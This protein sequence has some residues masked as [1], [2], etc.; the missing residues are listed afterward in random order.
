MLRLKSSIVFFI[1]LLSLPFNAALAKTETVKLNAFLQKNTKTIYYVLTLI[2]HH[3]M[4]DEN[5]YVILEADNNGYVQCI[6]HD[7]DQQIYCEASSG[8]YQGKYAPHLTSTQLRA[9][10]KQGFDMDA[11]HSNYRID[12]ITVRNSGTLWYVAGMMLE[13]LYRGY[14]VH[15]DFK[16]DAPFL[17]EARLARKR[18]HH[19]KNANSFYMYHI[20]RHFSSIQK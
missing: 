4:T 11:S 13:T 15:D 6:F 19:K 17:S 18:H 20:W 3:K 16:V 9:I 5:R 1:L 7:N 14:G 10:E 8:F 12:S 2:Q